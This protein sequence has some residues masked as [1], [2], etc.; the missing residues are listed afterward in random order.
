MLISC[1]F[2]QSWSKGKREGGWGWKAR[3]GFMWNETHIIIIMTQREKQQDLWCGNKCEFSPFLFNSIILQEERERENLV[4]LTTKDWISLIVTGYFAAVYRRSKKM[5]L[6][7]RFMPFCPELSITSSLQLNWM[8]EQDFKAV[9]NEFW[10]II[11]IC[12]PF[13]IKCNCRHG[14][15]ANHPTLK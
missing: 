13:L 3:G 15:H 12:L 8:R 7:I 11:L 10:W 6:P 5:V 4:S 14:C 1:Q 9:G 2:I